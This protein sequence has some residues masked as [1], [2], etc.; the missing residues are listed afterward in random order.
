V[1]TQ[2]VLALMPPSQ[3]DDAGVAK[4]LFEWE[5]EFISV[6]P[7]AAALAR[8]RHGLSN[9]DADEPP[10]IRAFSDALMRYPGLDLDA[11]AANMTR[12]F[13]ELAEQSAYP[14]QYDHF[15]HAHLC[16]LDLRRAHW[17]SAKH[18]LDQV[19]DTAHTWG[20]A[21]PLL[22]ARIL[23]LEFTLATGDLEPATLELD[24]TLARCDQLLGPLHPGSLAALTLALRIRDRLGQLDAARTL[25]EEGRRRLRYAPPYQ[26][27]LWDLFEFFKE[28]GPAEVAASLSAR[29]V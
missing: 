17:D 29:I 20:L 7:E 25:A 21:Y 23:A 14:E 24:A 13:A 3:L 2:I 28:H 27:I 8:I 18:H 4:L 26:T 12:R 1:D 11:H 10:A 22:R 5:S 9:G 6:Y 16:I 15:A 19:I